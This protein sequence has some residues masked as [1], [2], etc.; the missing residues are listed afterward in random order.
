M[1]ILLNLQRFVPLTNA[2]AFQRSFRNAKVKKK[3]N[4]CRGRYAYSLASV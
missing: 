1:H 4:P 3:K 2:L